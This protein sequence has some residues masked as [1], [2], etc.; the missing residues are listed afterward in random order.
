ML[1]LL[2]QG[3]PTPFSRKEDTALPALPA[4]R[5]RCSA[6]SPPAFPPG[7]PHP[8][9]TPTASAGEGRAG[10][11]AGRSHA[12]EHAPPPPP[13]H[14]AP[15]ASAAAGQSAPLCRDGATAASQ[16]Q[17]GPGGACAGPRLGR[18]DGEEGGA[19]GGGCHGR[20]MRACCSPWRSHPCRVPLPGG[21]CACALPGVGAAQCG[22]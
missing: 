15:R 12:N 19:E 16:S 6:P 17:R 8:G 11:G 22:R 21:S 1:Y 14:R 10:P 3:P 2:R 20:G 9:D 7:A 13:R 5:T 4:L 18:C